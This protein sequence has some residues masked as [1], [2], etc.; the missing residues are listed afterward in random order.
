GGVRAGGGGLRRRTDL[1]RTQDAVIFGLARLA[2]S[3][4]PETGEH[5]ERIALYSSALAA[6]LR[7]RGSHRDIVT[8]AFVE[9]LGTSSALHDIGKVGIEDSILRK[10]GPLTPE[11]RLR[12]PDNTPIGEQWPRE[13]QTPLGSSEF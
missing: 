13:V 12:M 9:Y 11:E 2:D 4:D 1:I 10:A 5:L 7:R 6:A 3:R 8:P